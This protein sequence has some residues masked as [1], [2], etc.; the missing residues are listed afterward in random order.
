M[1]MNQTLDIPAALNKK[2]LSTLETYQMLEP[3]DAVL[4]AVSGGPDSVALFRFLL[5]LTTQDPYQFSLGVAHLNHLIRGSDAEQDEA[6]V[7]KLAQNANVPF[8]CEKKDVKAHAENTR[9]S[10]EQAGRELR[11]GFLDSLCSTYGYTKIALGHTRDD[12]AELV[13]M[14]LLRGAAAKGLS[15]IPPIRGN[16]YIRPL[17]QVSKKE[18]L[19]LLDKNNQLFQIDASNTDPAFLR[20]RIRHHLIPLLQSEYN[21]EII[22]ALNRSSWILKQEDDYL[23]TRTA[24]ALITCLTHQ[25]EDRIVL[26]KKRLAILHP[27]L[28]NRVLRASI[29]TLK[30]NLDRISLK[31]MRNMITFCFSRT[32]GKSLDLPGRIRIY[33]TRKTVEIKK[34][35]QDLRRLGK[36]QKALKHPPEK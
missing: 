7:R 22:D 18:I 14:N 1:D 26:S 31:H 20:N 32:D 9:Q 12:N 6:F 27:A 36:T 23:E 34:E 21:P 5:N 16:R 2:I 4:A 10:V 17:I 13:L 25:D 28:L 3:G 35:K 29:K 11:Y 15:G 19:S 8:Y 33:K 30:N 24:K